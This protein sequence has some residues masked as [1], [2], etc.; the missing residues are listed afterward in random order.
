MVAGS[1]Y[2]YSSLEQTVCRLGSDAQPLR[3]VFTIRNDEIRPGL[4]EKTL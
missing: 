3:G 2:V 1:D 4:F